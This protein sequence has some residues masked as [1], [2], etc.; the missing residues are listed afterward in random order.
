MGDDARR[1]RAQ[2]LGGVGVLLLRHDRRARRPRVGDLAEAELVARPQHE[3][4]AEARE[5]GRADRRGAQVVEHEV[6]VGDGVDRVRRDALEAEL[7]G[8]QPAV[9]GE[10]HA[11]QRA[12][13][14]RQLLGRLAHEREALRVAARASRSRRAGGA[15]GRPAGRAAG[16]CSR[17]SPSRGGARRASSERGAQRGDPRQR[18]LRVGARE[19]HEVGGDLVVA[20][21]RGV[22]LAA[23]RADQVGQP[24]LDRHVDVDVVGRERERPA[25]ELDRDLVEPAQQGVALVLADDPGRREHRRVRAGLRDVVGPQPPVVADRG[26]ERGGRWDRSARRSATWV[27][28]HG[29]TATAVRSRSSRT[30]RRSLPVIVRGSSSIDLDRDQPLVRRDALRRR[31]RAARSTSTGPLATIHAFGRSPLRSSGTPAT[32]ASATAG[33]LEQH[34]LELGGRDLEAADLDQ[35]LDAAR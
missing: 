1:L 14:E 24:P 28:H 11:R 18:G 3:L 19:Q 30:R 27:E 32:Q 13:A 33:W 23:D 4:G 6:A 29:D 25:L 16:A 34:G 9:G 15:R 17:A 7:R 5:V 12:G 8:E 31:R 26:V 2:Q 35:L 20:R 10:V 21:A 22:E